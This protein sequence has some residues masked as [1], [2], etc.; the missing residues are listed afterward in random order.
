MRLY[1][2]EGGHRFPEIWRRTVSW[3]I[4]SCFAHWERHLP[5][6]ILYF[7]VHSRCLKFKSHSFIFPWCY[8]PYREYKRHMSLNSS[9][10]FTILQ[11]YVSSSALWL[12][13]LLIISIFL[14]SVANKDLF[15]I[16][17]MHLNIQF[18]YCHW[19]ILSSLTFSVLFHN[20]S[21]YTVFKEICKFLLFTKIL[22]FLK[23]FPLTEISFTV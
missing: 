12:D 2:A 4:F 9:K 3:E 22:L 5:F 1:A 13:D 17:L 10:F 7:K 8:P 14:S 19:M 23:L 16:T 21:L 18:S 11:K 15:F 6:R 20:I